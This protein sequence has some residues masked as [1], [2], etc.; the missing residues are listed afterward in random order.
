MVSDSLYQRKMKL[1][2]QDMTMCQRA[3][4]ILFVYM[5]QFKN[6]PLDGIS[7]RTRDLRECILKNCVFAVTFVLEHPHQYH[8]Y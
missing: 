6:L 2:C 8:Q 1:F 4:A 5:L 3:A 7:T